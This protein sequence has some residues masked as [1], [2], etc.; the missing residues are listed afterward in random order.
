[1]VAPPGQDE[2]LENAQK[3][4]LEKLG[5]KCFSTDGSSLHETVAKMLVGSGLT[6]AVAESCTGGLVSHLLT[7]VPGVSGSFLESVVTYSNE[8]KVQRLGVGMDTLEKHGA[9]SEQVASQ[10]A[11]GVITG[12]GADIGVATTG[13][14]GP[15]GATPEKPVGLV[16]VS[17]ATGEETWTRRFEFTGTRSDI[18]KRAANTA[19]NMIRLT[20]QRQFAG[21]KD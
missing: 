9:V 17:V 8:S 6:V 1:M 20:I 15:S 13:I 5:E 21:P 16:Y 18:K 12:S 14:A 4:L 19:L 3:E 10:M 7:E 2:K 11:E